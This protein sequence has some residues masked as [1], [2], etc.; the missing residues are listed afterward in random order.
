MCLLALLNLHH[1]SAWH[2]AESRLIG[3]R[4]ILDFIRSVLEIPYAEN[5]R[6]TIRDESIKP[7]VAAGLVERNPDKPERSVNSPATVYQVTPEAL[8]L[9]RTYNTP[10]W[11]HTLAE[12]LKHKLTLAEL[13]AHRRNVNGITVITGVE[14]DI[15]LSS[16]EHSFLIKQV[17]ESFRPRFAPISKVLYVGDTRK[18][19]SYSDNEELERLGFIVNIHG[20]MP[21]V[22]LY[23]SQKNWLILIECVTSNGPVDGRRYQELRQLFANVTADLVLITAFPDRGASFKKFL[24]VLAWETDVWVAD[25]P[26]HLIH[27]DGEKFLGPY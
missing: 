15:L 9:L 5:T 21:D 6:E 10:A 27:F 4:G 24:S 12:Y 3:I 1:D 2:T 26:D 20:Q 25:A 14:K 17:L 7:M 11:N 13:Y 16:G 18:K 22:I 23:E 8:E 19:W